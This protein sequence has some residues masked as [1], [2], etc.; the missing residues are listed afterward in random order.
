MAAKIDFQIKDD[1]I[2]WICLEDKCPEN[3]CGPY[4]YKGNKVSLF[5]NRGNLIPLIPR[6]FLTLE[7]KKHKFALTEDQGMYINTHCNGTCPFLKENKCSIY[8]KRPAGCRAY[9]F[10]LSKYSGLCVDT[11]CPGWGKGWT[12]LH[13]IRIMVAEMIRVYECHLHKIRKRFKL[14]TRS[15]NK[16]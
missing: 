7:S 4:D 8:H 13:D 10:F 5:G 3:C 6:D 15:Q 2:N 11:N 9:P 12:E 16:G 14:T 1:K